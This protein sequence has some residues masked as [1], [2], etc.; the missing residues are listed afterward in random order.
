MYL[1]LVLYAVM[2]WGCIVY[3]VTG[4][5]PGSHVAELRLQSNDDVV[6]DFES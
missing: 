4:I 1:Y 6:I 5:L 2:L 3:R